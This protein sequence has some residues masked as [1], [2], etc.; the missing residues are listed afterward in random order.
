MIKKENPIRYIL[1]PAEMDDIL[2]K[3]GDMMAS[4]QNLK[5]KNSVYGSFKKT[6]R[7]IDVLFPLKEHPIHGITG[8]HAIE[9][10][11]EH[12]N[13]ERYHYQ[14]K[15]IIPKKG[16]IFSHISAWE[17]EPHSDENT[18]SEYIV[19]TEPHHHHHIPGDR[20]QRQANENIRSLEAVFE[21]VAPYIRHGIEYKP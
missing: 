20:K 4:Y 15:R 17:N 18:P 14:W 3:Y 10:Y 1:L 9:K 12:G 5:E 6:K 13:V 19:K 11:N 16:V 2:E 21:Y 8:I 7:K